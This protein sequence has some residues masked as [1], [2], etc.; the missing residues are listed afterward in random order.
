MTTKLAG[1]PPHE[2]RGV[3]EAVTSWL[4]AATALAFVTLYGVMLTGWLRPPPDERML[5]RLEPLIIVIFG[6]YLGRLPARPNEQTL[7]EEI[8][9][10]AQKADATQHAKEQALQAREA[11][12]EKIKNARTALTALAPGASPKEPP[13]GHEGAAAGLD[14]ALHRAVAAAV[15]ILNS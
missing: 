5:A 1:R 4:M 2:G 3:A 6:Y 10:Q 7:R 13:R 9:R 14:E 12:E 8:M 15:S 11:L